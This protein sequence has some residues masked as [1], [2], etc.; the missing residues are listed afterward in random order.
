MC[1]LLFLLLP[2]RYLEGFKEFKQFALQQPWPQKP[3]FIFTSNNF[4]SDDAFK[5]W[6]AC[7]VE[8]RY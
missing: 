6:T 8:G 4:E 1:E 2:T 5:F 7:K 3:K